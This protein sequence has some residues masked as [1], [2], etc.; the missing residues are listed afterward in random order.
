MS[1]RGKRP[2][3]K[4]NKNALSK[5]QNLIYLG[6]CLFLLSF[7]LILFMTFEN[8]GIVGRFVSSFLKGLFGWY[9]K[10]I[11]FIIMLISFVLLFR[12]LR[13]KKKTYIFHI[14][15]LSILFMVFMDGVNVPFDN[16]K[17]HMSNT[18]EAAS[19]FKGGGYIGGIVSH[20]IRAFLGDTGLF[21][22]LAVV[23]LIEL[24]SMFNLKKEQLVEGT[25]VCVNKIEEKISSGYSKI[26]ERRPIVNPD[27]AL[28]DKTKDV[29]K[30]KDVF[31][32]DIIFE[33]EN[34][35]FKE[36]ENRTPLINTYNEF[37]EDEKEVS[38]EKEEP[39][40]KVEVPL[41]EEKIKTNEDTE[42]AQITMID[43]NANDEEIQKYEFP[44][45]SILKKFKKD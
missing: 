2:K 15:I 25:E 13:E 8:T 28:R 4:N 17:G 40:E 45:I 20:P 32:K 33:D 12:K 30:I 27:K 38:I 37:P 24:F 41:F 42:A 14:L 6:I 1:N 34:D 19:E 5:E 43:T 18:L 26:K 35:S 44:P 7:F 21:I 31:E 11:P 39:Q 10:L 36:T 3:Q 23:L 29:S 22:F 16:F 9:G